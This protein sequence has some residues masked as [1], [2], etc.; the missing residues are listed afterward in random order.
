MMSVRA[1]WKV[2][3]CNDW[4][5]CK[6]SPLLAVGYGTALLGGKHDIGVDEVK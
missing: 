1:I 4:W 6:M 2:T 3:R 5:G